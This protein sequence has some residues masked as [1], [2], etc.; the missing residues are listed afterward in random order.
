MT[1]LSKLDMD[2]A[3]AENRPMKVLD[4]HTHIFPPEVIAQR[5]QYCERDRCFGLLYTNPR[6]GM[7][8]AEG[9]LA[10]MDAAGVDVSVTFGLAF[11]DTGLCRACN[12]YVLEMA[13]QHSDRLVP[14]AVLNPREREAGLQE[15]RRCLEAGALG[16]GE[17][18]PDGQGF[19]LNDFSL[20]D[21]LMELARHFRAPLMTHTNEMVGHVY[22][23]KGSQG[24]EQ[25]YQMAAH[26]PEN[27]LILSH[28]G[29]GLPFFELMPEVRATLAQVYYDTAASLYLYE[30]DVFRHVMA[31]APRKVLWGSDYPLIKQARFL[32]RLRHS[33]L[34]PAA[35]DSVLGD[36]ARSAFGWP[37]LVDPEG[38]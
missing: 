34:E 10:S 28:W 29:G 23:G 26:Y 33:G 9:L 2:L 38:V 14:F 21:P 22:P 6:A 24:P 37:L 5:A 25:A 11:A 7:A 17:L 15:A 16:I 1:H 20:L 18:M 30:D 4:C 13:H 31:W 8:D 12:A 19:E 36:N 32:K 3:P 35:L 27:K